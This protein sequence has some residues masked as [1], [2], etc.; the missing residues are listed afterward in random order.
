MYCYWWNFGIE[1][2]RFCLEA[3]YKAQERR[4]PK[5]AKHIKLNLNRPIV[6]AMRSVNRNR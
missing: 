6:R 1:Y 5:Q 3:I 2:I 4:K